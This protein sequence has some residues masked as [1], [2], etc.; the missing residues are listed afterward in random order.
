MKESRSQTIVRHVTAYL[1]ETRTSMESYAMDVRQAYHDATEETA[2]DVR[3]HAGGDAYKDMRA[4]GQIVRRF[5]EG[6]PRMPV[7]IEEALVE[8]LP[9]SRRDALLT[10]LAAR[11]GLLPAQIPQPGPVGEAGSI[12]GLMKQTGEVIEAMA[13]MLED[14]VIDNR[15]LPFAKHALAQINEAMAELMSLQARV[16]EI[17]PEDFDDGPAQ[18]RRVK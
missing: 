11:Y 15:D 6:N 10:E 5:L 18:L 4:N 2:R 12:A 1:N 16:V 13:P 9:A 17:L 8:A 3:F 7:D 14:G